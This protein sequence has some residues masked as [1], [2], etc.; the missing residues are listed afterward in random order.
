M[1]DPQPGQLLRGPSG[2]IYRVLEV[3]ERVVLTSDYTTENWDSRGCPPSG[4]LTVKAAA[5][6]RFTVCEGQ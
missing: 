5:L 6:E 1:T 4:R 3:G 2:T